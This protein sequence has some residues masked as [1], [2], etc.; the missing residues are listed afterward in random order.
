MFVVSIGISA[1]RLQS[2]RISC[3][4]PGV[5]LLAGKVDFAFF[6]KTGTMTKHGLDFISFDASDSGDRIRIGMAVCHTLTITASGEIA[7]NQVD[8]ASFKATGAT[9]RHEKADM[10]RISFLGIDYAV[11]KHFEFDCHTATQSVIVEDSKGKRLIFVKGSPEAIK[12]LCMPTSL[13]DCYDADSRKVS[14]SGI[15]QIAMSYRSYNLEMDMAD[16]SR[17]DVEGLLTFGGFINFR[18]VLRNETE[19]VLKEVKL[20]NVPTAMLTGDN[21]LTGICVAREAGMIQPNRRVLL[22]RINN[23]FNIEWVDVDQ[24]TIVPLPSPHKLNQ[25]DNDVDL[26]ITGEAWISMC[27]ADQSYVDTMLNHFRVFGRCK[28]EVKVAVVATFVKHG[29]ITMMTGD[30][31]NDCGCLKTAH[32]GVA[33]SATEASLVAPF[34]SLD[35]S[36]MSVAEILRQGRCALASTLAAYSYYIIY[37]QTETFIQVISAYLSISFSEWCWVFLDG[38]FSI[39]LAFSLPLAKAA[40]VLSARRPTASLLGLET[41]CSICGILFWNFLFTLAA[42]YALFQQD[43]F[44]CRQWSSYDVSNPNAIGDNYESSV[45][46]IVGGFQYVA[47]AIVLNVGYSF[48]QKWYKNYTFVVLSSAWTMLF[49][50]MTINPSRFS[51]IWRVNCDNEVREANSCQQFCNSRELTQHR[52]LSV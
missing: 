4:R 16:V 3:S 44:Q 5:V 2:K 40:S 50:V 14:M 20:G 1:K 45:L 48:R 19:I 8:M 49:F 15:Y 34:T 25:P 52:F 9:L 17:Q 39:T 10:V 41:L 22:G 11:L 27:K 32:V 31:Q 21:V 12:K 24:N 51:C 36:L 33:L 29:F 18:N 35:E 47:S 42:L 28:P 30:G 26:A 37:G 7:G 38:V 23:G 13:P 46:F 43:W 6:D